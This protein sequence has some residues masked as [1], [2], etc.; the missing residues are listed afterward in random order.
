MSS[1]VCLCVWL[2]VDTCVYRELMGKSIDVSWIVYVLPRR[3]YARNMR[4]GCSVYILAA[5]SGV[6]VDCVESLIFISWFDPNGVSEDCRRKW[7]NSFQTLRH[8]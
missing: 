3:K 7:G 8:G 6:G 5:K 4:G 2:L 1:D